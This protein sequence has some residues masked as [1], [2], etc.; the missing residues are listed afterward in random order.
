MRVG[1]VVRWEDNDS[2]RAPTTRECGYGC[3]TECMPLALH[4]YSTVER[5]MFHVG[6]HGGKQASHGGFGGGGG[7]GCLQ[8]PAG[9]GSPP[10][11]LGC[12]H[13]TMCVQPFLCP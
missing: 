12:F 1:S 3:L 11:A 5:D 13:V 10:Q 2:A 4:V 6:V 9:V 8:A 7:A